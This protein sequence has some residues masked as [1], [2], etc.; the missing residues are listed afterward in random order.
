VKY[1][2]TSY[3][4]LTSYQCYDDHH[5]YPTKR[6][7]RIDEPLEGRFKG[8]SANYIVTFVGGEAN[9]LADNLL[10]ITNKIKKIS[11]SYRDKEIEE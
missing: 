2:K 8:N 9:G 7:A 10:R 11:K 5:T 3:G 1:K 6:I 4:P